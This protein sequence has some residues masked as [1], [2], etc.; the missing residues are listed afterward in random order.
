M[1]TTPR[2]CPGWETFRNLKAFVCTCTH[3]GAS[4]EIFSDEFDKPH[5]CPRCGKSIDYSSCQYDA[6]A[7]SQTPR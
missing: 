7:G 6:G 3:C 1:E 2:H 5:K 4:K